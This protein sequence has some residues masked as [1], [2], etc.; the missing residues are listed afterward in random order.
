MDEFGFSSP[1]SLPP[2]LVSSRKYAT[3]EA[4][5]E[6]CKS[7][8]REVPKKGT[9]EWDEMVEDFGEWKMYIMGW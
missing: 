2:N 6:W 5:I 4:A 1:M 8:G 3:D 7:R 9:N